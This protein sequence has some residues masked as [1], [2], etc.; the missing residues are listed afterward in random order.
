MRSLI[1][2]LKTWSNENFSSSDFSISD[3]GNHATL[4]YRVAIADKSFNCRAFFEVFEDSSKVSLYLYAPFGVPEQKRVAV[5]EA[6]S[7]INY[8][9]PSG[10][11]ELCMED[12][13][14]RFYA[15]ALSLDVSC[16]TKV[17]DEF[18]GEGSDILGRYLPAIAAVIYADIPP[19]V[20]VAQATSGTEPSEP[21]QPPVNNG[22]PKTW[23]QF[24]NSAPLQGWAEELRTACQTKREATAWEWVGKAALLISDEIGLGKEVAQRVAQDAGMRFVCIAAN[25]VENLPPPALF[26]KFTPALVYLEPGRWMLPPLDGED[27]QL[28][29]A[30]EEHQARIIKWIQQF[31]PAYPVLYVSSAHKI[32]DMAKKFRKVGIFDRYLNLPATSMEVRGNN[33]LAR[34]GSDLCAESVTHA[35]GKVGKLLAIEFGHSERSEALAVLRLQR[36]QAQENR[37]LEFIDLVYVTTRGLV[38]ENIPLDDSEELRWI[39]AYHEAGHAAVAVIDSKGKNVPDYVSSAPGVDTKGIVVESY[40]YK[41][42]VGERYSYADFRH[43]VRISL[44]GR[45]AEE[46]LFG[47]EQVTR[48]VSFDL[49]CATRRATTAF[50]YYGFAPS[51]EDAS[52]SATNLAVIVDTPS[53]SEMAHVEKLVRDF[54]AA[55]YRIVKEMLAKHR[56]F[57]DAIAKRLMGETFV[58]QA[59][60]NEIRREHF[61][62]QDSLDRTLPTVLV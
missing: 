55:E 40:G 47:S 30:R 56:L 43:S 54:L 27:A 19:S 50:S 15:N 17:Y 45:A 52:L 62:D 38:E 16:S 1:E 7:R 39:T 58:D 13:Q 34:L 10:R 53:A 12:G 60:L 61:F 41:Y 22:E 14:L 42:S 24:S 11:L 28:S 31:D 32:A 29:R 9:S 33:F 18:Q 6:V 8:E 37:L 5:A 46:L 21:W 35:L 23:D 36:L 49:E 3:D 59:E 26:R 57:L 48:G 44:A 2:A 25:D 51:M 20:A 4:K